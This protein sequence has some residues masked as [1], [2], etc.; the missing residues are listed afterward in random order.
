MRGW[1]VNV[2]EDLASAAVGKTRGP[3][4]EVQACGWAEGTRSDLRVYLV[5][6]FPAD[7]SEDHE[8][9]L[10]EGLHKERGGDWVLLT[11]ELLHPRWSQLTNTERRRLLL[12][13]GF[14]SL[15]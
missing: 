7:W 14:E 5:E 12:R 11:T 2:S 9:A 6:G 1:K 3:A 4:L 13:E 8:K 15:V 10:L